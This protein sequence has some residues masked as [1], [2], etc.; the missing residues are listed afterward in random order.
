MGAPV[1]VVMPTYNNLSQLRVALQALDQ[2]TY[3][4]FV[5]YVCVDGSTDGTLGYLERHAPPFVRVLIH[6]DGRNHG[7]NAARNLALPYL[8]AH[9]WVAFLDSDSVPL[10]DWLERFLEAEPQPQEVLL[11]QILYYS[12]TDSNPWMRYQRW[13]EQRRAKGPATFKHFTTGNLLLSAEALLAM[14]GFDGQ[15]RRHGLDDTELGWR[16]Q[17]AGYR[18]RYVSAAKV[19]SDVSLSL[20]TVLLRAYEMGR[21]NLPYLAQKHPAITAH[22]LGGKWLY[23]PWRRAVLRVIFGLTG[24]RRL[25]RGLLGLPPV[26]QRWGVRYL[27]FQA[28][29]RGYWGLRSPVRLPEV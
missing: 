28:V 26:W 12:E 4:D 2:Q 18:F 5:V 7:R 1:A 16:L 17:E 6:P 13:R 21:Y 8:S 10:P 11:G 9:R 20:G 3:R 22:L 25:I 14:G 19:W 24:T 23:Q 29:A 15:I 27:L